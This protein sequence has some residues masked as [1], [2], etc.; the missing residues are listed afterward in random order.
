LSERF[1]FPDVPV[2]LPRGHS[3]SRADIRFREVDQSGPSFEVRVFLNN[4]KAGI[5]T[6]PDAKNGYAG[7]FHI[8]GFGLKKEGTQERQRTLTDYSVNATE[9]VRSAIER[10]RPLSITLVPHYYGD[11]PANAD[12]ALQLNG[13]SVE[14]S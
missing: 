2:T 7:S 14:T 11:P 13:V 10:G 4:P 8:Y 5:D 12:D 3:F 9:A 1:F 6:P